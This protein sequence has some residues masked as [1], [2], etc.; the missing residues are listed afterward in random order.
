MNVVDS[1]DRSLPRLTAP[2]RQWAA[3]SAFRALFVVPK[4][5]TTV[6]VFPARRKERLYKRKM[7]LL[8]GTKLLFLRVFICPNLSYIH[9]KIWRKLSCGVLSCPGVST[10]LGGI[11]GWMQV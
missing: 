10:T 1:R 6:L 5:E 3:R 11:F 8:E 2:Q 7:V 4:A 9:L